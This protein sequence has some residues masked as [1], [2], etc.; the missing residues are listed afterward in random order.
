MENEVPAISVITI[1]KNNEEL[2]PRAIDSVLVQSFTDFEHIIVNDGSTDSTKTIIDDYAA[3]DQRVKPQHMVRNVGRAMARNTG[4]NAARGKYIFFLDSDDYLPNTAF[5]DLYE[6][7]E[8]DNADIVYGRIKSFNPLNGRWIDKH[9]TDSLIEPERHGFRLEEKLTLLYDHAIIG[10]LYR[11]ELLK[12]NN[13]IFSTVRKNGED[14]LFSFYAAFHA[15]QLTTLPDKLSYFYSVGNYF[16]TANEVKI[17]DARDNVLETLEFAMKYG[18]DV[19]KKSMLRKAAIFA[20]NL[21]R[22]Q[23]V[24]EGNQE[25]YMR[26]LETLPPLIDGIPD[27]VLNGLPPY[28]KRFAN[29][30]ILRNFKD[31]YSAWEQENIEKNQSNKK[32]LE[33]KE[34]SEKE[35]ITKGEKINKIHDKNI[36]ELEKINKD[37]SYQLDRLYNT[38]SWRITIPVR[39]IRRLMLW[40]VKIINKILN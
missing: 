37:L 33:K 38:W 22:V 8:R 7:A 36:Y 32:I 19:I 15:K 20:A 10:R 6:V 26:Y 9:Y 18:S 1:V 4:L 23:I 16:A 13:I 21:N 29:A 3:K 2:L 17:F 14:V 40:N 25:K 24:Y 28:H 35:I 39:K 5:M 12:A 30:I 31:A 27:E 34:I 11:R